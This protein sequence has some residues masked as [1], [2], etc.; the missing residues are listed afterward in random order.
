VHQLSVPVAELLGRPGEFRD[1]DLA[2]P[3]PGVGTELAR[4]TDDPVSARLRAQSVIEGILVTGRIEGRTGL[5]CA[6]CLTDFASTIELDVCELFVAPGHDRA[7]DD[8]YRVLGTEIHLEAMLRDAVCL[9]L[10]LHPLCRE[11]CKGI[12]AQCGKDLN[13]GACDCRDEGIDPRWAPLEA[14]RAA[15]DDGST[16]G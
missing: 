2:T 7:S 6:R 10:P 12:C 5:R 8:S 15:L 4:L 9:A 1:F 11:A 3:L 13:F 16:T 14:L